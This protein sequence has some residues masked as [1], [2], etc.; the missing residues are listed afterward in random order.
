MKLHLGPHA[1]DNVLRVARVFMAINESMERLRD[2]YKKLVRDRRPSSPQA[3]A[4]WPNPTADP[5]ESIEFP[6]LEFFCKV[7]RADGAELPVIDEENGRHAMYHAWMEMET[8]TKVVFVK[9]AAKY[10]EGAHR[11]LANQNP[12]LA[13]A[14]YF[15]VEG[16]VY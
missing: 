10:N 15:Q 4:L 12:P 1:S 2:L 6:K 8:E 13:P 5:S 14:L 7:N 9:F 16:P 11:L 3:K